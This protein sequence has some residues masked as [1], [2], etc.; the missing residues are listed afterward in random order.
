MPRKSIETPKFKEREPR[1]IVR[2]Y[3][4]INYES[5]NDFKKKITHLKALQGW[6]ISKGDRSYINIEF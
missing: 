1:T 2:D 6:N 3:K 5:L 4:L